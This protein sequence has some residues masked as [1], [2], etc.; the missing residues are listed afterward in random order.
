MTMKPGMRGWTPNRYLDKLTLRL[1]ATVVVLAITISAVGAVTTV[2]VFQTKQ[3][4]A[5]DERRASIALAEGIG[6]ASKLA[7]AARD[8]RELSRLARAFL[9]DDQVLF[10]AFN[11]S[12]GAPLAHET[13]DPAAWNL[14]SI[15]RGDG[16]G[17]IIARAAVENQTSDAAASASL[18]NEPAKT[19]G[20]VTVALSTAPAQLVEQTQT[21]LNVAAAGTAA[22]LCIFVTCFSVGAWARRLSL[23]VA[24]T[25]RMSRGD[26]EQPI[27]NSRSDEVGRLAQASERM[28]QAIQQRDVDLRRFNETLQ[29]QVSDRTQSLQDALK[30]AEAADHA[31]SLFLANMSHEIRTPLNGVVGMVDL[32]RCTTLDENQQRFVNVARSSAD[33]LLGVINDILDFS[34][35][36]AGRIELESELFDLTTVIED[37]VERASVLA[38]RKDL[39]VICYIAPDVPDKAIGDSAR[40]G[41]VLSNLANNAIK[42]TS[43]GQITVNTTLLKDDAGQLEIKFT[44]TDSGIGIPEDRRSRLFQSF[45]QID[46]STTRKYGGTGL[47]LAISKRLAELMGGQ[48][49][50]ESEVGQGSTFWF[51]IKLKA[52]PA[53]ALTSKIPNLV[54]A[55]P[56]RILAV[57]DNPINREILQKQL[58]PWCLDVQTAADATTALAML[59][60]AVSSG[61]RFDLAILDW[62]MPE[63]DGIALAKT[64]RSTLAIRDTKL[65]ML[66]SVEDRVTADE[67]G[68]YGFDAHL[69]KPVRQS[70]LLHV[71]ADV[72]SGLNTHCK[73]SAA[74]TSSA[75]LDADAPIPSRTAHLLL[76]EDNEINRMVCGEILKKAGFTF[77]IAENGAQ[78]LEAVFAQPY[79]L[80]LMDCQMPELDGFEATRAIRKREVELADVRRCA[81][82]IPIVALTANAIKG[83]REQC[84]A[85]GMD[86][87]VT[88]PIEPAKLLAAI[89]GQLDARLAHVPAAAPLPTTSIVPAPPPQPPP[90]DRT[91]LL[92]RCMGNDELAEKLL[93]RFANEV[94]KTVDNLRKTLADSDAAALARIAHTL[95]GTAANVSAEGIRQTAA[96]IERLG[97]ESTLDDVPAKLQLLQAEVTRCLDYI[98]SSQQPALAADGATPCNRAAYRTA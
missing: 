24:A 54:E 3:L 13:R 37:L 66:T 21:G 92:D 9:K 61:Q 10:V 5:G 2:G 46:A 95:K 12:T 7:L 49:G 93:A 60:D 98:R 11:D 36:E 84:L 72:F 80:V 91:T 68:G 71:I 56:R 58:A 19:L 52:A 16:R 76:A 26:F 31:K 88:K 15:Y 87:Y 97:H 30:A 1:K 40:I 20:N 81:S 45:S 55:R 22:L 38:S 28:R 42:F 96:T 64:I 25:E 75:P 90:V 65:I 57:D 50:V 70:R 33:A 51:T 23:L 82:R 27:T 47:G 78:A 83:D 73:T 89:K 77:D 59:N 29:Q 48:I 62:H 43:K 32:L 94:D 85:A 69:V 74:P 18:T 35:I 34:K 86:D 17:F 41:Q 53:D 8:Q 44:V 4:I 39:E 6:H 79:D 63:I 67:L 14:Y